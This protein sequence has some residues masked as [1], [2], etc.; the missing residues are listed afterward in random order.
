L[1]VKRDEA[2]RSLH[3]RASYAGRHRGALTGDARAIP[4]G[5]SGSVPKATEPRAGAPIAGLALKWNIGV[6]GHWRLLS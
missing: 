2:L 1:R 5:H 4:S 3:L 6:E